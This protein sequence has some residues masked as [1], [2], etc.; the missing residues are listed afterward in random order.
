MEV[1]VKNTNNVISKVYKDSIADELGIE[2]GD[3]LISINGEPIHDII[4]YRFLL[5]DEYLE[6][7]IQKQIE[8]CTYMRLKR[9]MMMI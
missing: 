3:L 2:V 7:E 5:S 1:N 9:I 4:E 8:K 6:V